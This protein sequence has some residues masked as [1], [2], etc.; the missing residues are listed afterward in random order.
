MHA[1]ASIRH[2]YAY[3]LRPSHVQRIWGVLSEQ[4]GTVSATASCSDHIERQF[5]SLDDLLGFENSRTRAIRSLYIRAASRESD[6]AAGV[7]IEADSWSTLSLRVEGEE[8]LVQRIRDGISEVFDGMRAWYSAIARLDFFYVVFGFVGIAYM[9]LRSMV[10][11]DTPSPAMKL[12][13]AVWLTLGL[14][15]F[16]AALSFLVWFLN[17]IR[18]RFFPIATI[19]LGQGIERYDFDDKVRWVVLVGFVVSVFA[20]IVATLLLP[21]G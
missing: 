3:I 2:R 4:I 6:S 12:S 19:A 9:V 5:T 10:G 7:T 21:I 17:R 20:S 18:Q 16:I 14:L 1:T 8:S 13:Q 15:G 11:G